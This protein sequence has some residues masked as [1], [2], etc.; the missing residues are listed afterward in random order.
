MFNVL[1]RFRIPV[2]A[3]VFLAITILGIYNSYETLRI[4]A[5][6]QDVI[7]RLRQH[8]DA[9]VYFTYCSYQ[10]TPL[11]GAN[12]RPCFITKNGYLYYT[13]DHWNLGGGGGYWG[14]KPADGKDH[15]AWQVQWSCPTFSIQVLYAFLD[16]DSDM[17]LG[18][19]WV[20]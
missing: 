17:L 1:K 14:L 15:Y 12:V 2:I 10:E 18:I 19:N 9:Q 8:P 13:D 7:E 3:G 16:R 5:E 20:A 4:E 6:H 11:T